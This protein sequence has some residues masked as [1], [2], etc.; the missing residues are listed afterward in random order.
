[1]ATWSDL[2]PDV[3]PYVPG[4]PDP[5]LEQ[6]IRSAAIEF[7]QRT[8]AWIVWLDPLQA[9]P[10]ER[11]YQLA[12]PEHAEVVRIERA[13]KDGQPLAVSGYRTL[14]A[15]P[16]RHDD[17]T[18][19]LTSADRIAVWLPQPLATGVAL[20]VQVSLMPTRSAPGVADALFSKHRAAIAE[21]AKYRLMTVPG[22]LNQ[23]KAAEDARQLFER[24][25]ASSS[26]DAWRGHTNTTPRATPKW[27]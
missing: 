19:G 8:R 27:C 23:P 26:V 11:E 10:D 9:Q 20:Q 25:V 3:L 6:E 21:G 13:T 16:S 15:D 1:M 22:P 14:P 18:A 2:I 5:M 24:A 12:L 7:F 4:C 17:T